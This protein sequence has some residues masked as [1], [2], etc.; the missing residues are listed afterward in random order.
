MKVSTI[1]FPA[2]ASL[3]LLATSAH[4]QKLPEA[5]YVFPA[6]GKAGTTINVHLGGYDWTPDMEY[7]V[8]DQRVQLVPSGPP[9]AFWRCV[10]PSTERSASL[11]RRIRTC[12]VTH[13][14]V[15]S[16]APRATSR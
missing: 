8:H 15:R 9:C 12:S 1:S 2:L 16:S 5:G 11:R 3:L 4:G 6:G 14:C 13:A 10:P 7:F